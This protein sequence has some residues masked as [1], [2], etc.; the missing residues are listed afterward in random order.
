MLSADIKCVNRGSI[1]EA[2]VTI[3]AYNRFQFEL[4]ELVYLRLG[5]SVM[6]EWGFDKYIDENQKIQNVGN[7][8][9]ENKWFKN[10]IP[11]LA[12]YSWIEHYRDIYNFHYDGFYGKVTNFDW[13]FNADGS[14]DIT[15]KQPIRSQGEQIRFF[16]LLKKLG[17]T[18]GLTY[19]I[20]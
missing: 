16:E 9:I 19:S 15:L 6:L 8:L 4:L 3:K 12:I 17:I 7:T 20:S 10:Q 5:Y 14:Y 1:R 13:Q 18:D 2:T 11:N